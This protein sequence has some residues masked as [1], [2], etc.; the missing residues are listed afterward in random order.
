MS[1]TVCY[2]IRS[3]GHLL[4]QECQ[5]DFNPCVSPTQLSESAVLRRIPKQNLDPLVKGTMINKMYLLK[6]K[7]KK[8]ATFQ[9]N[10]SCISNI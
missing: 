1:P 3:K 4:G 6:A 8:I 2:W 5:I 9:G 10:I 7:D